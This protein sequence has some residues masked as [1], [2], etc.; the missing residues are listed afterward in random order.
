MSVGAGA[1]LLDAVYDTP[2]D[3]AAR[4]V[5]ADW[6][7]DQSDPRGELIAA[8]PDAGRPSSSARSRAPRRAPEQWLGRLAGVTT[9]L[10]ERASRD[11]VARVRARVLGCREATVQ[12]VASTTATTTSRHP[13]RDRG[14]SFAA[15]LSTLPRCSRPRR[16]HPSSTRR[17]RDHRRRAARIGAQIS[18]ASARSYRGRA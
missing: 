9:A 5:Y 11:A 15:G 8:V 16:G 18:S 10:S 4:L 6:L 7:L 13:A 17:R 12:H 1:A 2:H 14:R 3:D